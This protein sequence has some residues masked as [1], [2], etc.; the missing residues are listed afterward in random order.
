[1]PSLLCIFTLFTACG[2]E[3]SEDLTPRVWLDNKLPQYLGPYIPTEP[4]DCDESYFI[5]VVFKH[6]VQR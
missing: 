3:R 4:Q 1:M 2:D 5:N 6:G